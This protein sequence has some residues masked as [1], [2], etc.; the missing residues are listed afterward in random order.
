VR[1]KFAVVLVALALAACSQGDNNTATPS[2]TD[3]DAALARGGKILVWSWEPTL[4]NVVTKF[5]AKYPNVD[6]ELV[7]AGTGGKQYT[8]LQNAIT[9]GSGVPDVAH[10][11]YYALPQF[12]LAKSLTALAPFGADKLDGTFTPGP[13][14]G[15]RQGSA[16]FGLPMDSGP[17]A[18]FYNDEVFKKH[19]VKVP[20][21][22]EEYLDAARKLHA[23]DANLYITNDTG[24]AGFTTSMIW[25]AGGRPYKVDGTNVTIDFSQAETRKFVDLW[26]KLIDE[27]LLAPIPS[28]SDGWNKGL[29]EG[30]IATL[31]IGAWMPANLESGAK[32]GAGKWRVADMP[33]WTAGGKV[34]AENGGSSLAVMDKSAN[35]ALAYAFVRY[36]T[37]GEGAT[38][39]ASEGAFP[40]TLADLSSP[41]FVDKEFPY[42]GGQKVN[43]VLAQAAKNV[44]TGWSYLPFQV[45][46]NDKFN[47]TVG[48]AYVS[49]TKLADG[50]AAWQTD[51]KTYGNAQGFA[52]K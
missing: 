6:V 45:Y 12:A 20:A 38:S 42:F 22:W 1:T 50:L 33:Q 11:E 21:T 27:K 47:D 34:S 46:V 24:D 32:A 17:M 49:S 5:E 16:I 48:K 8:A 43:Q 28:W 39:R 26:Q 25:Q 29:G 19:N 52:V 44:A 7:N 18:L 35:K 37:T 9:A 10:I 13:W 3:P 14:N 36:A 2:G 31:T 15:V 23:A 40:A 4:K 51:C 41:A 30:T